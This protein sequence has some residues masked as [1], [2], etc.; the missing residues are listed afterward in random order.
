MTN[1]TTQNATVYTING[2]KYVVGDEYPVKDDSALY[3]SLAELSADT[4]ELETALTKLHSAL[5]ADVINDDEVYDYHRQVRRKRESRDSGLAHLR[6]LMEDEVSGF[7]PVQFELE[8]KI[9][10][11]VVRELA[12]GESLDV[13]V[14]TIKDSIGANLLL[15]PLNRTLNQLWEQLGGEGEYSPEF[16]VSR[17]YSSMVLG[18][19]ITGFPELTKSFSFDTSDAMDHSVVKAIMDICAVIPTKD[20]AIEQLPTL[21]FTFNG[22]TCA[23]AGCPTGGMTPQRAAALFRAA[24]EAV[25]VQGEENII[26]AVNVGF[27]PAEN[28]D[29]CLMNVSIAS[30][31]AQ[32][33]EMVH[34]TYRIT[35]EGYELEK[36][37]SQEDMMKEYGI[38]QK[39]AEAATT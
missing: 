34:A 18:A 33:A 15:Y 36:V 38:Q 6:A 28:D 26:P 5:I 14:D 29:I 2:K 19:K 1:T 35:S 17:L 11:I 10:R 39:A 32:G 27:S 9:P 25:E 4:Y 30:Q 20:S 12:E 7:L 31:M 24:G 23:V 37:M 3:D 16:L 8:G 21:M 22:T 13:T